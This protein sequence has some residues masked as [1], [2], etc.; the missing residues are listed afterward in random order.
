[1]TVPPAAGGTVPVDQLLP[2]VQ[3]LLVAPVHVCAEA[4]PDEMAVSAVADTLARSK[5]N[6][7]VLLLAGGDRRARFGL[8]WS[9]SSGCCR[10]VISPMHLRIRYSSP[11]RA[12]PFED[13]MFVVVPTSS[14]MMVNWSA[15]AINRTLRFSRRNMQ[16][17][18]LAQGLGGN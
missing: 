7:R 12:T 8:L 5:R 17:V 18:S 16:G 1:M 13:G 6:N 11:D 4:E 9:K 10:I 15:Q 14:R 3:S 2:T